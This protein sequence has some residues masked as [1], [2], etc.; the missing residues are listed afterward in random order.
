M[1]D[2]SGYFIF[3]IIAENGREKQAIGSPHPIFLGIFPR[4][5]RGFFLSLAAVGGMIGNQK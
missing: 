4:L 5:N 2:R 3:V 1:T